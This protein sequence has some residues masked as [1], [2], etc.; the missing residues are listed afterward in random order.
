MT[1][2][3]M[4]SLIALAFATAGTAHAGAGDPMAS[5]GS[6]GWSFTEYTTSTAGGAPVGNG[7]VDVN[8]TLY[9]VDEKAVNGVKSWYVFFDPLCRSVVDADITFS[10]V[11]TGIVTDSK[12]LLLSD[13]VY[14]IGDL[15]YL[16]N[17]YTGLERGDFARQTG[18]ST[19]SIHW[20]A[21]DPGDHVRIYTAVPEPQTY[22]LLL[23]GLA[24]L[25]LA[26]RR[27]KVRTC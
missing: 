8:K 12:G 9:F 22:A 19:L 1:T 2:K 5:F 25:A 26:T 4:A 20:Q 23:S 6:P 24:M 14:G 17:R 13:P 11:I 7:L 21:S 3:A 16:N 15:T 27:R 10:S 18:G